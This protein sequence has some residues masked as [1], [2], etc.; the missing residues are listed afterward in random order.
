MEN[1]IKT[2]TYESTAEFAGIILVKPRGVEEVNSLNSR[3]KCI[4]SK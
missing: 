4:W 1:S 2:T 3:I